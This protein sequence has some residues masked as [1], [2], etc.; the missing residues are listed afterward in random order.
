MRYLIPLLC[1]ILLLNCKSE[2]QDTDEQT[3]VKLDTTA[4]TQEDLDAIKYIDFGLDSKA[5]YTVES[6]TTF[7]IISRAIERA[8]KNDF[9]VFTADDEVFNTMIVDAQRTIPIKISSEPIKARLLILKTKL[10]KFRALLNL[11]TSTKA[12]LL[13]GLQELFQSYSYLILQ[14]NKKFEK[15]AQEIIKPKV[16]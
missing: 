1:F 12:D 11:K 6:W 10:L 4:I 13:E 7:S 2:K 9:E 3:L 16:L 15:E 8:K 14:I 5:K